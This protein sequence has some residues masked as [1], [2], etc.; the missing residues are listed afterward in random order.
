MEE[1]LHAQVQRSRRTGETFTVLMLDLDHFKS[2]ND[3]F[4][5]AA[6]DSALKHA[7]ALLKAGVREVDHLAR[8]GGEEFLALM[9]GASLAA[10]QPLAERLRGSPEADWLLS[11]RIYIEYGRGRWDE[12]TRANEELLLR[13]GPQHYQVGYLCMVRGRIRLARGDLAGA[14]D[15]MVGGGEQR[16]AAEREDHRIGVQRSQAA[17]AEPGDVK[18]QRRPGQLG[19]DDNA[20]QHADDAPDDRGQRKRA[21]DAVLVVDRVRGCCAL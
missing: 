18:V 3:R 15:D 17:I 11:E 1:A 8:F 6:G 20:D 19:G 7:A 10:A 2:I 12:S 4:G 5:H 14:L 16:A 13:I 9:P 21:H